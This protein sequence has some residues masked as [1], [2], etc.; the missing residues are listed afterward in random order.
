M[1]SLYVYLGSFG[2]SLLQEGLTPRKIALQLVGLV[3]A[4]GAAAYTTRV[5]QKALKPECLADEEA[6]AIE[7]SS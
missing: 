2:V 4:I 6:Q 1:I 5:T 7:S 3:L